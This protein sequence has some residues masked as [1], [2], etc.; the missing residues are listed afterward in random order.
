MFC[1]SAREIEANVD[2][3]DTMT[4]KTPEIVCRVYW[5]RMMLG[6]KESCVFTKSCCVWPK[7]GLVFHSFSVLRA[8]NKFCQLDLH[9]CMCV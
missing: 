2:E 6:K 1:G 5:E 3:P 8:N 9:T 4:R 7:G